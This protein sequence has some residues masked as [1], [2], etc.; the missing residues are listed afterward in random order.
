SR[1]LCFAIF[2]GV[3]LSLTGVMPADATSINT[4]TVA[5]QPVG[6]PSTDVRHVENGTYTEGTVVGPRMV[7][8]AIPRSPL[9]VPVSGTFYF[10][11][12]NRD[13]TATTTCTLNVY[14]YNGIFIASS[15]FATSLPHWSQMVSLPLPQVPFWS[16]TS[17]TCSLPEGARGDIESAVA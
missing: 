6:A 5:C 10:T 7:T 11:G 2:C 15:S 14:D 3:V 1:L 16:Y 8:C 9:A 17:V 12:D 4:N 13:G